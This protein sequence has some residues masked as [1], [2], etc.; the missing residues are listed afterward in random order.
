MEFTINAPP[1]FD[2]GQEGHRTEQYVP[3]PPSWSQWLNVTDSIKLP[4]SHQRRDCP[5][6]YFKTFLNSP[7]KWLLTA[8]KFLT[9]WGLLHSPGLN[10]PVVPRTTLDSASETQGSTFDCNNCVSRHFLRYRGSVTGSSAVWHCVTRD[11]WHKYLSWNY[12]NKKK[13]KKTD[14][15]RVK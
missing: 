9:D 10:S 3:T 2:L 7:G 6:Y 14:P 4:C 12:L 15:P 5:V 1:Y 13:Y 8:P 11:T